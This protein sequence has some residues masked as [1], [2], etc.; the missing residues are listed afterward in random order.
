MKR[1]PLRVL[2]IF[3]ALIF[4]LFKVQF[5]FRFPHAVGVSGKRKW[6]PGVQR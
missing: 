5:P 2:T 3:E 6:E 1:P 4:A